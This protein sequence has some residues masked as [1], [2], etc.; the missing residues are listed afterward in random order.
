MA[1]IVDDLCNE[2]IFGRCFPV[3]SEA[4][5]SVFIDKN[6][7]IGPNCIIQASNHGIRIESC[8]IDQPYTHEPI[9]IQEGCWLAANVVILPGV[10]LNNGS[11]IGAGAVVTK[12]T[13]ANSI[14]V[15]VPAKVLR[16]RS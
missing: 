12:S 6:V 11:V 4:G 8:I 7:L 14:S 9:Y 10:T 3:S 16:M 2:V 1:Y 13:P 5:Q 15:G